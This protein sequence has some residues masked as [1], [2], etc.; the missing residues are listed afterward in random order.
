MIARVVLAAAVVPLAACN[1]TPPRAAQHAPA[2][3]P[4][5]APADAPAEA[6]TPPPAQAQLPA[7]TRPRMR[8]V[9]ISEDGLRPDAIDAQ[10]APNHLALMAEGMVARHAHTVQ[11]SETLPSHASMLSGFS[12]AA[13]RL[14][15]DGFDRKR[16]QIELPTIF[17]IARGAGLSTAM[18]VGKQ[19]LWHI[20]PTGSVDH[21]E[22]PGFL[23]H[24]VVQ[25]AAAY[26]ETERPDLTFVHFADPDNAGHEKRWMSPAYL[27]AVRASDACLRTML[28]AIARSGLADSTLVIVTADHGGSGRSHSGRG[29]DLDRRIPWIVR[30][31][32]VPAGTQLDAEVWTPDTAVTALAALA[33]PIAP[34]MVGRPWYPPPAEALRAAPPRDAVNPPPRHARPRRAAR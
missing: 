16:G 24:T 30:G 17:A 23:C 32:A 34:G 8:V 14:S 5:A 1:T 27:A 28:D 25:R 20:A 9:I 6:P 3:A 29:K 19:K 10:H 7:V 33:L 31:P 4:V 18:F 12:V 21:Y 2:R 13:H 11:P 15:F 22:K 26:F